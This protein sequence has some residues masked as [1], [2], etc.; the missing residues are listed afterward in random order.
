MKR[1][2]AI[3]SIILI[4]AMVFCQFAY[5]ADSLEITKWSPENGATKRQPN[6]LAVKVTFNQDM[7]NEAAI[8]ANKNKFTIRGE[9]GSQPEFDLICSEKAGGNELWL[10]CS[11]TLTSNT[12]YT[13]VAKSGIKSAKGDITTKEESVS[14]T[15]RDDKSDRRITTIMMVGMLV[16]MFGGSLISAKKKVEEEGLVKSKAGMNPYKLAKEKGITVEEAQKIVDKANKKEAK[17]Q[18][19]A[20]AKREA[21]LQ[22]RSQLSQ[23]ELDKII[24]EL[25][26][27]DRV[28]GIY[29]VKKRASI[30]EKGHK[31]PR[32]V[33]KKNKERRAAR[34]RNA[35]KQ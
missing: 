21:E 24:K 25:D 32:S 11:D 6:G 35:K 3:V 20:Q 16:I 5:A 9:D 30:A 26:H 33:V 29:H 13:V 14:F 34:K 12:K 18:A 10:I 7:N 15:T 27:E 23:S 31:I 17:L 4:L 8:E 19:K 2:G 1:T 28:N 22:K